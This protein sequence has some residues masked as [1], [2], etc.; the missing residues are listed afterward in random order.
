VEL[1]MSICFIVRLTCSDLTIVLVM[2]N[3]SNGFG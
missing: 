2:V 1:P 3:M